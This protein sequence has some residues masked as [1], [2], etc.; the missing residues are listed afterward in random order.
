M[1]GPGD[2]VT[3]DSVKEMFW[4][5]LAHTRP[6]VFP[7]LVLKLSMGLECKSQFIGQDT[8]PQVSSSHS[9]GQGWLFAIINI[10]APRWTRER[11]MSCCR[12]W[13]DK[14]GANASVSQVCVPPL[15]SYNGTH[16]ILGSCYFFFEGAHH[17]D[18]LWPETVIFWFGSLGE[19]D[20]SLTPV[21]CPWVWRHR[22]ESQG[23]VTLWLFPGCQ[24]L[25]G[26]TCSSFSALAYGGL[27]WNQKNVLGTKAFHP[28]LKG[29]PVSFARQMWFLFYF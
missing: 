18:S 26:Q 15:P 22:L 7:L 24:N 21:T 23:L 1:L 10:L 19:Q 27:N 17:R 3:M 12:P 11:G 5:V 25:T 8:G 29:E 13:R 6:W 20:Y 16:F 4:G 28:A 14:E 2:R 9:K